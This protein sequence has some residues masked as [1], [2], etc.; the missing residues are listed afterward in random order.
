MTFGLGS[1][2]CDV[3]FGIFGLG[4]L[5]WDLWFAIFGLGSLV[6]DIWFVTFGLDLCF[7]IF[8]ISVPNV[9]FGFKP[10]GQFTN[11]VNRR[12]PGKRSIPQN[13]VFD[14]NILF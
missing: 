13:W 1:L 3:W 7:A 2:V 11:V 14:K 6:W 12:L 9:A 4:S 10:A 5:V 8:G